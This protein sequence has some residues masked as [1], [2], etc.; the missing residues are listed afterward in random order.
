MFCDRLLGETSPMHA[1]YLLLSV[2]QKLC[3]MCLAT[4]KRNVTILSCPFLFFLTIAGLQGPD[5][6]VGDT[7]EE[8]LPGPPGPKGMKG[9]PVRGPLG[10]QGDKGMN[11]ALYCPTWISF[12]CIFLTVFYLDNI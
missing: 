10:M 5:G 3:Q 4:G 7:G 9:D 6:P 11:L 8:G 1:I 12:Q 2:W